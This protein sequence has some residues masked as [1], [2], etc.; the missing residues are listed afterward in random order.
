MTHYIMDD[1]TFQHLTDWCEQQLREDEFLAVRDQIINFL[2]AS[3]VEDAEY[4]IN[5]GWWHVHDLMK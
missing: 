3:E 5:H 2:E 1:A 4:S